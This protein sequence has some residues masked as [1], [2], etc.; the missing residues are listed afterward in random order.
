MPETKRSKDANEKDGEMKEP[1]LTL[2]QWLLILATL[3]AVALVANFL[4]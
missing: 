2:R 1:V 3:L 4:K